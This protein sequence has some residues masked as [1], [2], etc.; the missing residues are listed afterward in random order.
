MGDDGRG[1]N[2]WMHEWVYGYM[3]DGCM[4]D[5]LLSVWI[6]GWGLDGADA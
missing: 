6:E 5:K 4:M 1:V 3:M 2:G